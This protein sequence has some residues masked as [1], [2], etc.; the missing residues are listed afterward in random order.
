[1]EEDTT[2]P[3]VQATVSER[4]PGTLRI[5]LAKLALGGSL[6]L[7]GAL[8]YFSVMY[9][10]LSDETSE[11]ANTGVPLLA[12]GLVVGVI[13]GGILGAKIKQALLK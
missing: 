4:S 6:I 2:Q 11:A 7:F 9:F 1:M 3:A 12:G 8:G 5:L 10:I 13:I